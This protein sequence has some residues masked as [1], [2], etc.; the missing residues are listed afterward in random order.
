[1]PKIAGGE[2]I[3]GA[4]YRRARRERGLSEGSKGNIET[5]RSYNRD[6][7]KRRASDLRAQ[8][9]A[10]KLRRCCVDCGYN[11]HFAGLEFDHLPAYPKKGDIGGM[12]GRNARAGFWEE[13][14][15]C[16]VVCSTCHKVRTWQ[17]KH[18]GANPGD[19]VGA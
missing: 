10:L 1:M 12:T 16:E 17:R 5:S 4:Q 19:F 9:R 2:N 6:L 14:Q 7:S 15:K 8:L 11:A 3:S 18:P 13:V